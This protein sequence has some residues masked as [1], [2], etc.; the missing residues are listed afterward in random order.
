MRKTTLGTLAAVGLV[1]LISITAKAQTVAGALQLGLGTSIVRYS[2]TTYT[3]TIPTAG[4]GNVDHS[5]DMTDTTWGVASRNG[6]TLEVGYGLSDM[7][8]LG[9]MLQFGGL[10]ESVPPFARLD[11]PTTNAATTPS[12]EKR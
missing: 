9:G 7:F 12:A 4:A 6:A 11:N 10:S 5:A 3:Q 1:S 2:S 8:V